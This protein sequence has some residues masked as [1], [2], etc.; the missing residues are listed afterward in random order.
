MLSLNV[1]NWCRRGS[2]SI[3]VWRAAIV[4]EW[5]WPCLATPW[6]HHCWSC[7]WSSL[8]HVS[9]AYLWQWGTFMK[10]KPKVHWKLKVKL[11][12][13]SPEKQQVTTNTWK[14]A[15]WTTWEP[16]SWPGQHTWHY[17][18]KCY[19][20]VALTACIDRRMTHRESERQMST[21]HVQ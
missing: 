5:L 7:W 14:H 9:V 3:I 19:S 6:Q 10:N 18:L 20:C 4:S 17:L 12:L 16:M 13:Q 1:Q 2:L 11:R 21:M 8:D 15:V